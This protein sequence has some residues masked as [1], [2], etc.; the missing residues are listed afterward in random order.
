MLFR[1]YFLWAK[2]CREET[3]ELAGKSSVYQTVVVVVSPDPSSSLCLLPY[4]V[5][6]VAW[7]VSCSVLSL[8][9]V[10]L[11]FVMLVERSCLM[12]NLW[13]WW[14]EVWECTPRFHFCLWS[15]YF[16]F[17]VSKRGQ[18]TKKEKGIKYLSALSTVLFMFS[19]QFKFSRHFRIKVIVPLKLAKSFWSIEYSGWISY[20]C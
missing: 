8:Q 10:N 15:L 19:I 3:A 16:A 11:L 6:I 20:S 4:Y 9:G 18:T 5:N 12:K 7:D 13:M 1:V 17:P 14:A 2:E